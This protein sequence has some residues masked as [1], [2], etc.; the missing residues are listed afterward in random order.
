MTRKAWPLPKRLRRMAGDLS[1]LSKRAST[2]AV[3]GSTATA[4]GGS[5]K[6]AV[7]RSDATTRTGSNLPLA[8]LIPMQSRT[9]IASTSA[10][11]RSL[12]WNISRRIFTRTRLVF[13]GVSSFATIFRSFAPRMDFATR[14]P[15]PS[16]S[17]ISTSVTRYG[18]ERLISST[19]CAST[20]SGIVISAQCG[21][22]VPPEAHAVRA[23][24]SS[25]L[26]AANCSLYSESTLTVAPWSFFAKRTA[27]LTFTPN[28]SSRGLT[29][30]NAISVPPSLT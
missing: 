16:G 13:A 26:P 12:S 20:G 10:Y 27:P 28:T 25:R 19:V 5:E 3:V 2:S 24:S 7:S 14:Q 9:R 8:R 1:A 17:S 4:E 15:L 23:S 30:P 18:P 21:I 11:W 22:G 6:T 29:L